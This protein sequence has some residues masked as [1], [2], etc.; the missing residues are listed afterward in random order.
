MRHD[1][2]SENPR[3]GDLQQ[4]IGYVPAN[5]ALFRSSAKKVIYPKERL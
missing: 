1:F 3:K 5:L 2:L 4:L